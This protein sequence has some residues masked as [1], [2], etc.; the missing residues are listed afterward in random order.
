MLFDR[1]L[2]FFTKTC[3][4]LRLDDFQNMQVTV[5]PTERSNLEETLESLCS[6]RTLWILEWYIKRASL[7]TILYLVIFNLTFVSF[8]KSDFAY[9]RTCGNKKGQVLTLS[10]KKVLFF[11]R[12]KSPSSSR[13]RKLNYDE[14]SSTVNFLRRYW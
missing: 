6:Q 5:S 14:E 11:N 12:L 2:P 7:F 4:A 3:F 1:R 9:N 8:P 13:L 10:L